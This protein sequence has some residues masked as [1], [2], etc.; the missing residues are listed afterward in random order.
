MCTVTLLLWNKSL[1]SHWT[2]TKLIKNVLPH[3]LDWL[4]EAACV[5]KSG[6]SP[7]HPP[8]HPPTPTPLQIFEPRFFFF[9]APVDSI[10][11][12][13]ITDSQWDYWLQK[14]FSNLTAGLMVTHDLCGLVPRVA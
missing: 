5:G 7:P 12:V 9:N 3:N 11:L 4:E 10:S 14:T 1:L 6:V 8:Q 2:K 13:F